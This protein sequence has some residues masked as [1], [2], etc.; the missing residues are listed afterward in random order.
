VSAFKDASLLTPVITLSLCGGLLRQQIVH[1]QQHATPTHDTQSTVS[2]SSRPTGRC[3]PRETAARTDG[4][5]PEG[6]H[7]TDS[8]H[9]GTYQHEVAVARLEFWYGRGAAPRDPVDGVAS[10]ESFEPLEKWMCRP[11]NCP[12]GVRGVPAADLWPD[13]LRDPL[14]TRSCHTTAQNNKLN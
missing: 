11:F 9:V 1:V 8:Q 12:S 7:W 3:A 13:A 10:G 6:G 4:R 14:R 2:R 5:Q